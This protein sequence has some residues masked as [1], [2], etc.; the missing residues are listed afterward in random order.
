MPVPTPY[1]SPAQKPAAKTSCL[2]HQF[3]ASN[4]SVQGFPAL[5]LPP[6]E[7]V[8]S[9]PGMMVS[10]WPLCSLP[11]PSPG[12]WSP[13]RGL[14]TPAPSSIKSP[15]VALPTAPHSPTVPPPLAPCDTSLQSVRA[16]NKLPQVSHHSD[17]LFLTRLR[18]TTQVPPGA[19]STVRKSSRCTSY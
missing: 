11:C 8:L 13:D 3:W 9:I 15:A 18:A 16:E 1:P 17:L 7:H 5:S 6:T 12:P 19:S 10:A 14:N 4:P 2:G